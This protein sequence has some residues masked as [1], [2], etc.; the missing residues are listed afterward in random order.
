VRYV[1][2]VVAIVLGFGAGTPAQASSTV[3]PTLRLVQLTPL[4]LRGSGFGTRERV[5]ITVSFRRIRAARTVGA[6][7]RGRF[8]FRYTTL[9][10]LEP[11]RGTLVVTAVGTSSGRRATFKRPCRPPDP[12]P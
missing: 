1:F 5:R 8:T 10:A 2:L 3:A 7:Q 9:L 12:I 4:T 6:D 11:C